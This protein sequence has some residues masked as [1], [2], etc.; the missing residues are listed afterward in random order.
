M[1]KGRAEYYYGNFT[2][3]N[4]KKMAKYINTSELAKL[5][6]VS[7]RQVQRLAQDGTIPYYKI[8]G[9]TRFIEAEVDDHLRSNRRVMSSRE[10]FTKAYGRENADIILAHS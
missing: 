5:L 10:A 1:P 7:E 2:A 8:G 4:S 6:G 9:A 3:K